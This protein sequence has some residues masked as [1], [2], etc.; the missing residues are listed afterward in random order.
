MELIVFVTIVALRFIIPLFIPRFPVPAIILALVI[1]AVDQTIFAAF[2]VEPP[3]YQSYDKALDIYYL[4][5]AYIS[6]IRNWYVRTPFLA[7]QGL[8]YFRLVGVLLFELIGARIILFLFPNTFEYF[9]IYYESLRTRWKTKRITSKHIVL[10]VAFIWIFIKL[11]QEYW[12]HVAQLDFTDTMKAYPWLWAVLALAVAALIFA[13]REIAPK[14]P[15]ADKRPLSFNAD[16]YAEKGVHAYISRLTQYP[17]VEKTILVGI[18]T[19][20][21][22]QFL[23]GTG[24]STIDVLVSAG[25]II[26]I[27]SF[28]STWLSNRGQS[29]AESGVSFLG[30]FAIN[31]GLVWILQL[32]SIDILR[33]ASLTLAA[34][35][36]MLLTLIVTLYDRARSER[37]AHS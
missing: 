32:L 4:S 14:L 8:W 13:L 23:P 35:L 7:S 10:A 2:N 3:N 29:W 1:D 34:F 19:T 30:T 15:P 20:I 36:L 22:L 21:F 24:A 31:A 9:F 16:N 12:I 5:I 33:G 25:L 17:L 37:L 26:F 27:S 28:V 18:I 11:P 6:T